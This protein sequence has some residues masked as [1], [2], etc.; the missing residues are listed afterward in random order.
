M[1]YDILYIDNKGRKYTEGDFSMCSPY[2]KNMIL[3]MADGRSLTELINYLIETKRIRY[4]KGLYER[5]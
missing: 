3:E 2:V 1:R 4:F 5:R